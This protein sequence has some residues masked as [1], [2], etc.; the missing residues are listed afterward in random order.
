MARTSI[1]SA[2]LLASIAIW[3]GCAKNQ[4]ATANAAPEA[5]PGAAEHQMMGSSQMMGPGMMGAGDQCP[6]V[7]PGTAVQ[8][9]ETTDGAA[10]TFTTTGDVA[11]LRKRVHAMADH[12][13]SH[14]G[15]GMHGATIGSDGGSRVMGGGM[16]SGM[17]AQAEDVEGG[18]LLRMTPS[19]S[20]RLA[21]MRQHMQQH[22][23]MMN[24]SHGCPMMGGSQ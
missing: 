22:A 6:M 21:E 8:M 20:S 10:M 4:T 23:Q 15:G 3:S 14:S 19:D 18:A 17:R 16:M 9:T 1:A 24:Q 11:E 12:V 13:N 5:S 7:V 2:L